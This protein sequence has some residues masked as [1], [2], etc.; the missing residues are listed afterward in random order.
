MYVWW[1]V[2]GYVYASAVSTM[3]RE[4][5]RLLLEVDWKEVVSHLELGTKH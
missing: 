1:S 2:Y 5:I 3:A 4:G